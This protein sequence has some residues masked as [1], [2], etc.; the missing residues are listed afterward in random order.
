MPPQATFAK[1]LEHLDISSCSLE[2]AASQFEQ[3]LDQLL[4]SP[5]FAPG[6]FQTFPGGPCF[7]Q[8][9]H[10]DGAR[11]SQLSLPVIHVPAVSL[12]FIP[13][14]V[15]HILLLADRGE[16]D[17]AGVSPSFPQFQEHF[18]PEALL[19][20][21]PLQAAAGNSASGRRTVSAAS[22]PSRSLISDHPEQSPTSCC[23]KASISA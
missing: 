18:E 14:R 7:N 4:F 19:H 16:L 3:F 22:A 21:L 12:H 8:A 20:H 5:Q 15:E 17:Q 9:W 1:P 2:A 11:S 13:S 23:R 10:A 6:E